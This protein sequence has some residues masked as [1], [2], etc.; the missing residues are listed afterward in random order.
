[1]ALKLKNLKN[2][3]KGVKELTPEQKIGVTMWSSLGGLIGMCLAFGFMVYSLFTKFDWQ[4]FGFVIVVFCTI[5][6]LWF[7]YTGSK[8]QLKQIKDFK[9]Q[10]NGLGDTNV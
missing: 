8:K 7:Q 9:E 4:Q 1:M 6:M 3:K 10:M 5:P 2:F